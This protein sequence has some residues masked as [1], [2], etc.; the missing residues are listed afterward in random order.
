MKSTRPRFISTTLPALPKSEAKGTSI[1]ITAWPAHLLSF[2]AFTTHILVAG[3][4]R[5]ALSI[6]GICL[7]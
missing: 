5:F 4:A 2:G 6:G 1:Y 7:S 3:K